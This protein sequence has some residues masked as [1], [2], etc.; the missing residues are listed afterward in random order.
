MNGLL[1]H[2]PAKNMIR[3]AAAAALTKF[4]VDSDEN[5]FM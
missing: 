2:Y 3:E 5:D 1:S 4:L